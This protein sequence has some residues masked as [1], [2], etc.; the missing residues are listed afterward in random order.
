MDEE[1]LLRWLD[2]T[3]DGGGSPVDDEEWIPDNWGDA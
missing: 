1:D 3:G 2:E